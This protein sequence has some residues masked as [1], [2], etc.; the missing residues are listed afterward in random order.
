M[1]KCRIKRRPSCQTVRSKLE[2][3]AFE[4]YTDL[5]QEVIDSWEQL[6]KE[7]L[8]RFYSTR[9]NTKQQKGKPVIDYINR[10]RAIR[11]KPHTFEELAT[12]AHDMELSFVSR[13]TKNFFIPEVRKDKKETKG[14]ENIV[15][16]TVKKSMVINTTPLKFSKIKEGE[17]KRRMME[18][19]DVV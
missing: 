17:L 13:G 16:S 4:W 15:K 6:E 2:R 19:K 1:C 18:V 8:N 9:R 3:N 14:A 12:R 10:W 11:I 5:E 7:F